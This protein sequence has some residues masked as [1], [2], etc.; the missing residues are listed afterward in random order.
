MFFL[1]CVFFC[2]LM[3]CFTLNDGIYATTTT[4]KVHVYYVSFST[5]DLQGYVLFLFPL[6]SHILS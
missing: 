3:H 1:Q 4:T 2:E 6:M 5:L